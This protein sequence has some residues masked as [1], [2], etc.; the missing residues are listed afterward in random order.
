MKT[1]SERTM[2][3]VV[4]LTC[5]AMITMGLPATGIGCVAEDMD[6]CESWLIRNG[7]AETVDGTWSKVGGTSTGTRVI[8]ATIVT[9]PLI[10]AGGF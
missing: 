7:Y 9:K 6:G 2:V 5:P 8:I 3:L 1:G 10:D 4:M